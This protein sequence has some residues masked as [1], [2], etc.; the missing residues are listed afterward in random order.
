MKMLA[1]RMRST[2]SGRSSR[3]GC[4]SVVKAMKEP[5]KRSDIPTNANSRDPNQI[6]TR[7]RA[8]PRHAAQRCRNHQQVRPYFHPS[9]QLYTSDVTVP[10]GQGHGPKK[11]S[12]PGAV[13]VR[14]DRDL[15]WNARGD[16]VGAPIKIAKR[17]LARFFPIACASTPKPQHI[18][19]S[20]CRAGEL[21][22]NADKPDNA[23]TQNN[24]QI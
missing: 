16:A 2:S 18:A 4:Q 22:G 8:S 5:A 21:E 3:V 13:I 15:G 9:F 11:H 12:P 23:F 19:L 14:C 7:I 17:K 10:E 20:P 6:S 1:S 24:S